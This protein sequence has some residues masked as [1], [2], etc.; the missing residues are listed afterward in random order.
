MKRHFTLFL[1]TSALAVASAMPAHAQAPVAQAPGMIGAGVSANGM[2]QFK[3]ERTGK[4]WTPENVSKDNQTPQQQAAMPSTA[5]D[6]AFDPT[7]QS[8]GTKVVVQRPRG[9]LMG[10]VPITAGPTVP[11]VVID[12]PWLQAV[13]QQNWLSVLYVTN[14]SASVVDPVVGCVFT[15]GGRPVQDT[16][17]VLSPAGPGERW[18]VPVYGPPVSTFVDRVT[19][20][21][22]SP[23]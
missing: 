13:P 9:N 8:V 16:R 11:S 4:V 22:L 14:N 5:A 17:V 23:A 12:S 7:S 21:L 15:N 6:K 19:C 1:A 2:T 20:R 10:V 3:D 18:G